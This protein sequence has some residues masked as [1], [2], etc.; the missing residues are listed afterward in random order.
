MAGKR[1]DQY[2]IARDE[3]SAT[4]YK[5][6]PDEPAEAVEDDRRVS[7]PGEGARGRAQPLLPNVP[8]P[9]AHRRRRRTE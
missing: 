5:N 1:Y 8:A 2:R 9:T 4:D 3:A 7:G 6:L